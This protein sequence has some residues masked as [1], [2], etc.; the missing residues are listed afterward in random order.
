MEV[1]REG[2]AVSAGGFEAGVH[3][4]GFVLRESGR[5]LGEAVGIVGKAAVAEF[6]AL[7]EETGVELPFRDVDAERRSRHGGQPPSELYSP[8]GRPCGC[9]LI[10]LEERLR[11]P[12]GLDAV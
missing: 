2:L 3:Q 8:P 9:K 5:E 11:I 7:A 12:T 1:S 10:S 6:A 4:P